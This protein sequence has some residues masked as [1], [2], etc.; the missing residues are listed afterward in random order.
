MGELKHLANLLF[1]RNS[2]E[3][4]IVAIIRRPAITGHISRKLI[5]LQ[6]K[7]IW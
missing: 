3:E 5:Q 4:E 6:R 1:R 2:N 7:R